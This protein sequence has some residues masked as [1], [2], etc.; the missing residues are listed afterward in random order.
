[1]AV[2][3]LAAGG[4]WDSC[5]TPLT[6]PPS[7]RQTPPMGAAQVS[8]FTRFLR[9]RRT[10][11]P[12][13]ASVVYVTA[14]AVRAHPGAPLRPVSFGV[15]ALALALVAARRRAHT[16]VALWGLAIAVASAG[17]DAQGW[18]DVCGVAGAGAAFFA[19]ALAVARMT[20]SGG[21]GASR[22][23]SAGLALIAGGGAWGTALAAAVLDAMGVAS[24]LARAPR[25]WA[26]FATALSGMLVLYLAM[27]S[28][29]LRKLDLGVPARA[30]ALATITAS[31]MGLAAVVSAMGVLA[32]DRVARV[33]ASLAAVIV[34]EVALAADAV[35]IAR[36]SRRL[37]ALVLVAGPVVLLGMTVAQERPRDATRVTAV[38]AVLVLVVGM[39]ARVFERPLRPAQGVWLDAAR[40]AREAALRADPEDA[41][42]DVLA[43]L[44]E[45]A[46]ARGA[47]P[48][49][50]TLDPKRAMTIDAAGY[51]HEKEVTLPPDLLDIASREPE[52][53]L[54]TEVLSG[55]EVRRPDLRPLLRWM[56]DRGATLAIVVTRAGE[57]EGLLVLP[58]IPR[59]D[60]LSLEEVRALKAV[61][62]LL[63]G[64]IH[65]RAALARSMER[66]RAAR[67]K[68][69]VAEDEAARLQHE[70]LL[71]VGRNA[72]ATSRLARPATV[73]IY[74]AASRM[75]LE[76]VL[77][78]VRVGAPLALV[79]PSGVDP[80]P[81]LARAHLEGPRGKGPLVLVDGTSSREHDPARWTD[82][83]TSPLGLADRGMLVLLDG[84]ALPV[85]VQRL[86]GRVL[87][88]RRAPWEKPEPLDVALAFTAVAGPAELVERGL[89]D[90]SLASRLGDAMDTPIGLPRLCDRPED[91]RAILTDRLAREGL[92]TLG[93]P[94]GVSDAAFA[95][96]VENPFT[97]EEA[98]LQALVQRL[99]ARVAA[100]GGDVVGAVD[101]DAEEGPPQTALG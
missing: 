6:S 32:P 79:V 75:A 57:P 60:P 92:R 100:R 29:R 69:E 85:D 52:A 26:V 42:C 24:S 83:T 12:V 98:E 61:A 45:P 39:A 71:G 7:P 93:R 21:L 25:A 74:S 94:L 58:Q 88:E 53:A 13:A 72:L 68:A 41:P 87:A 101:V 80:V 38:T 31:A 9:E 34:A 56:T 5:P 90:A 96:L 77:R 15:L 22:P 2:A 63:A 70:V 64:A 28:A 84:A 27:R 91:I 81:Y 11:L 30:N 51:P 20:G 73:G 86:V 40:R 35:K 54:R 99:V 82:P 36:A 97:G 76:A 18:L 50:L 10:L 89:L 46:G 8:S 62:D 47:S 16:R 14:A 3:R 1:M 44:R 37:V 17:A 19:A 95:R 67:G 33:V 55:L 4:G 78:R 23:P 66:E 49:L 43:V 59:S 65:V 48:I